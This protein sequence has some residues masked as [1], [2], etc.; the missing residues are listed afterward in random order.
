[1]QFPLPP[2]PLSMFMFSHLFV[3]LPYAQL[4]GSLFQQKKISLSQSHLIA[5]IIEPKI[6]HIFFS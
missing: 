2:P 1:M 5:E 3:S 6:A 4:N